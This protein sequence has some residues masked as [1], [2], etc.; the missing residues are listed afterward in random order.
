MLLRHTHIYTIV[1]LR[2]NA[3]ILLFGFFRI[4]KVECILN[5]LFSSFT[6]LPNFI[7]WLPNFSSPWLVQLASKCHLAIFAFVR[8]LDLFH[9]V[10]T[11]SNPSIFCK[12]I[13]V[14]KKTL[15]IFDKDNV[16][17][18]FLQGKKF[19]NF[20][21]SFICMIYM[22]GGELIGSN[23]P[24]GWGFSPGGEFWG[25]N[26]PD[27]LTRGFYCHFMNLS[28]LTFF[29]NFQWLLSLPVQFCTSYK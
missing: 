25:G 26:F 6:Y 15:V 24:S 10:K 4:H 5:W 13:C 1:T 19:F 9:S 17:R 21:F 27:T 11:V 2:P 18:S 28:L 29:S 3:C 23:F 7:I 16:L 8:F 12:I 14:S 22:W 20:V